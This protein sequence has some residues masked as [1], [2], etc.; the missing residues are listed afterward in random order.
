MR[1]VL[2]L[3]GLLA[4]PPAPPMPG[5]ARLLR[6]AGAPAPDGD[7][8]VHALAA[9]F[10]VERRGDWPLAALRLRAFGLDPGR[11]WWLAADPVTLVAGRDDVRLAGPVVDLAAT[12]ATALTAALDAHFAADGLRFVAATPGA[13]FVGS[14][15]SHAITTRPLAC[16][17]GAPL[18]ALLP[19][20][21]ASR[22]WRRWGN[23]IEMLLHEH[24]VNRAREAEGRAVA[25]GLWFSDGGALPAPP[26]QRSGVATFADDETVR[27]LAVHAGTPAQRVPGDLDAARGA[28]P[29]AAAR[30]VVLAP[31][32]APGDVEAAWTGPLWR[33]FAAGAL[34]EVGIVADGG[35][36]ALRWTAHRPGILR[37]LA[38][39][40][41]PP[42]L[43][44]LLPPLEDER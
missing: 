44:A 31:G 7:T 14:A 33:A 41:A 37:R 24:P 35:G 42:E 1:L 25:N 26:P 29:E 10:G 15:Q 5:L 17:I 13:W 27:A 23:E 9:D 20:G 18:R 4:A 39:R 40:R 38:L 19:E 22:T 6:A 11:D 36:R 12:E 32:I 43:S 30:F 8:L 16:A 28:T 34:T 2:G 3:P 21:P